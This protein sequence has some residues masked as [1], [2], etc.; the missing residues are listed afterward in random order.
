MVKKRIF[1]TGTTGTMGGETMKQLLKRSDRFT[2]V[3]LARDSEKNRVFMKQYLNNSNLEIVWGDITIYEDVLRCV[4]GSDYVV[5]CAA[6]I[7]PTAD[8]YPKEAMKINYGGTINIIKAIQAQPNKDNIKFINIG[9]VAETGDRMAPIHWGRVG[10]PLKPSIH[11]YYAVSKIAAERAVIESGLKYWV[12]LRQ[13]GIM[14]I[15][16]FSLNE[17]IAFHQPLNNVLEWITA[18]DSGLLCA[19]ACEDWVDESFWGHVYNIGGGE[20]CRVTSYELMAKMMAKIGVED[21]RE[22]TEPNWY[23]THNFH[24]QWYLDSDKLNDLLHF[25]TQSVDDFVTYYG[26][27]MQQTNSTMDIPEP[28]QIIQGI[29][30]SNEQTALTDTGTLHWIIHNEEEILNPFF[31]SRKKWAEIP[32]WDKYVLYKPEGRPILLNHGYDETKPESELSIEDLKKAALF[33]GGICLSE[34]MIIGDW[35]SKLNFQCHCGHHFSAS[36]RLILEAGHWCD[37]CERDSWNFHELAKHSP[38]FAQVWYPLH[39]EDERSIT[40]PKQVKETDSFN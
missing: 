15:K 22:V 12:S 18:Y 6:F 37:S 20:S 32:G 29:R 4:T 8:R 17:G 35:S 23:A 21:F 26:E 7:S 2:I 38:F 10:D 16:E 28:Q 14:S 30:K 24:G 1:V 9:T 33:R 13:T 36:P 25:R 39:D 11:D 27:V 34:K 3:T 5:H 31:I 40:Y 19:N